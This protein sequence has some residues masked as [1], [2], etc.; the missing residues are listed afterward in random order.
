MFNY[1]FS[2]T[3]KISDEYDDDDDDDDNDSAIQPRAVLRTRHDT[4]KPIFVDVDDDVAVDY[5]DF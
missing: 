1:I 2:C 3:D 5:N 4:N